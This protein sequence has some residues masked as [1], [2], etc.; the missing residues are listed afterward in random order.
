[1]KEGKTEKKRIG[2]LGGT[3]NPIHC[4]HLM[5]AEEAREQFALDRVL[6][7]PSGCS[8]MKNPKEVLPAR[9]RYEMTQLAAH[10]NSH[11]LVS[12]L[13]IRRKGNS[14]TCETLEELH[15]M[16]E[17]AALFYIV[18]ADTLFHMEE[19]KN[20]EQIFQNAIT[21]AAARDANAD[22]DLKRQILYLSQK[23]HAD[24]RLL[25]FLRVE[26]SSTDIRNR[27]RAR[28]SIRYL[29]PEAVRQYILQNGFYL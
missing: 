22:R 25:R 18:G 14:Y 4:G 3:F 29:V 24:I 20:P 10:D 27:I 5:L 2:I 16:Y 6:L 15:Q 8:Y 9:F 19:W 11:L 12:D 13:E 1:M 17:D 23:Y 28:R 21:V 26:I 7:I